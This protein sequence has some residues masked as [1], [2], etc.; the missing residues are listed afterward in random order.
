MPDASPQPLRLLLVTGSPD[1]A[2]LIVRELQ[3]GGFAPESRFVDRESAMRAALA[4]ATWDAVVSEYAFGSFAA[5]SA[6]GVLKELNIDLPFIIVSDP[7]GEEKA[8]ALMRA[9]AHDFVSRDD[10]ARLPTSVRRELAAVRDR[11]H[12]AE[13]EAHVR[14]EMAAFQSLADNTN[15]VVARFDRELRHTY[16]NRKATDVSGIAVESF[17]GKTHRDLGMP[18][19]LVDLLQSAL[20]QV[21]TEGRP[22]NREFTYDGNGRTTYFK[23]VFVPEKNAAGEVESVLVYNQD[24]TDERNARDEIQRRERALAESQRIAHVGSWEL[25][26][27]APDINQNPLRWSDEVFRIFGLEPGGIAVTNENFFRFVSPGDRARIEAAVADAIN[28]RKPYDL[29]HV[30]TRRDGS[31]RWVRERGDVVVDAAGTPVRILGTVQDITEKHDAE[32][33]L[34]NA[35]EDNVEQ[36]KKLKEREALFR[37]VFEN[38]HDL[39]N[40][41]DQDGKI[42]FASPSFKRVLGYDPEE[43]AGTDVTA[44]VHPDDRARTVEERRKMTADPSY[45]AS[46]RRRMLCKDGSVRVME[47]VGANMLAVPAVGALVFNSRDVTDVIDA[48][49]ATEAQRAKHRAIIANN[50]DII[51]ILD[52]DGTVREDSPSVK[53]VLGYDANELRGKNVFHFVHPDDAALVM[54]NFKKGL[55]DPTQTPMT[56]YRFRHKDGTWRTLESVGKNLIADPAIAGILINSRDISMRVKAEER[57]HELAE[58]KNK[59]IQIVAHQFRT[60]LNAIRWNLETLL[61]E[62]LGPMPDVQKQFIR[63]TYQANVEVINRIRDLLTAIDIEEGRVL[64]TKETVSIESLWGSVL[65][66]WKKDCTVKGLTCDYLSPAD[67]LPATTVDPDKIRTAFEKLTDNAVAYTAEGGKVSASLRKTDGH[68]RFEVKD[69]GIGIPK[70]EQPRLFQRFFRA[71]NAPAMK[72]DA[73]GL[74]LPIA[75]HFVELHGGTI[76]FESEE[77]KGSTF[78]FEIPITGAH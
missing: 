40:L 48:E 61:A 17:I 65:A 8:I 49:S 33:A 13:D 41:V 26:L 74:G 66:G 53:A 77:G 29:E 28:N 57:V 44:L 37:S 56:V 52:A 16:V 60:P 22:T 12:H 47:V 73:S 62:E 5:S 54:A 10:L 25:D 21:F 30:L 42:K 63:V 6:L 14:R 3:R 69:T 76:G 32:A 78:W 38:A 36:S 51:T 55:D 27:G 31:Q 72:P 43:I 64:L 58:L 1:D 23:S 35:L 67:P 2:D 20:R 50:L 34:L 71:T 59:F 15:D 4:E 75:K 7:V 18:P 19:A 24:V 9:G 45:R 70:V 68:I 39:V 11:R 46:Y